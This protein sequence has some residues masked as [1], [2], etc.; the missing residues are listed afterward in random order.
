MIDLTT[1]DHPTTHDSPFSALYG[2]G[3]CSIAVDTCAIR[4]AEGCNEAAARLGVGDVLADTTSKSTQPFGCFVNGNGLLKF[5]SDDSST[6][7]APSDWVL[8][9]AQCATTEALSTSSQE[10]DTITTDHSATTDGSPFSVVD[11]GRDCSS[12]P[13]LCSIRIAGTCNEAAA[14]LG[15]AD[16][17][18]DTTSKSTQ[19]F[20]C[21]INSN[22]L[23]KFN[24]DNSSTSPPPSDW[25]VLCVACAATAST[26]L[27]P[28]TLPVTH[29]VS[30]TDSTVSG[31]CLLYTSDAADE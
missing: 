2:G 4:T 31:D 12:D 5:N 16:T 8:L 6:A 19:P 20:G 10:T 26:T 3:T 15:V 13:S 1:S 22:E 14:W 11:G 9:C 28:V 21:F 24:A 18:A 7:A 29:Q 30:A 27:Q 17:L 25:L 23:L